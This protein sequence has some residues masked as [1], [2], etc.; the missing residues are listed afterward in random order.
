MKKKKEKRLE[1]LE[2]V[3]EGAKRILDVGCGNA[4]LTAHLVGQGREVIGIDRDSTRTQ[5]AKERLTQVYCADIETFEPPFDVKSFDCIIFADVLDCLVEP[6]PLILKYRKY[7]KD[8][9]CVI[10]SMANVRYFKVIYHLLFKGTWDY[11]MPGG[12]LWWYHLRF[13]TLSTSKE[14]FLRRA[15]RLST[16]NVITPQTVL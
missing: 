12:I 14:L 13:Y 5:T 2:L 3:P 15:W 4:N 16:W 11:L 9:G 6:L 10:V 7:L 8:D 1:F